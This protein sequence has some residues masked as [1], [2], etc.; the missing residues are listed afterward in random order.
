MSIVRACGMFH[1]PSDDWMPGWNPGAYVIFQSCFVSSHHVFQSL[2]CVLSLAVRLTFT[3]SAGLGHKLL[4]SRVVT[5][6]CSA[7]S[8]KGFFEHRPERSLLV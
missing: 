2:N 6:S 5:F 8:T 3:N 4:K 1:D 7:R